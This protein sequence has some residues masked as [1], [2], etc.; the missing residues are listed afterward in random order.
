MP[1]LLL[2]NKPGTTQVITGVWT[3][4]EATVF[5]LVEI[6]FYIREQNNLDDNLVKGP[7][8]Y[9]VADNVLRP[10]VPLHRGFMQGY[11]RVES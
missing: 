1:T 4:I 2:R 9:T 7:S 5:S 10:G 6:Y 11:D 8:L 3:R